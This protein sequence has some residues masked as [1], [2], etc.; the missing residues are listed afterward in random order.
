MFQ[1]D[2]AQQRLERKALLLYEWQTLVWDAWQAAPGMSATPG[3]RPGTWRGETVL[4]VRKGIPEDLALQ[5]RLGYREF[6][7]WSKQFNDVQVVAPPDFIWALHEKMQEY[8]YLRSALEPHV[9]KQGRTLRSLS[10]AMIERIPQKGLG[11]FVAYAAKK[12]GETISEVATAAGKGALAGLE[13]ILPY[14]LAG[15]VIWIMLNKVEPSPEPNR[16]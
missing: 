5:I 4:K 8:N 10:A 16:R 9:E 1:T 14:A 11:G 13:A 12:A 15:L 6:A 2:L 3:P 7:L